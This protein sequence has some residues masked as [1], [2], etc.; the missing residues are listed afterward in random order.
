MLNKIHSA[1]ET[2][3]TTGKSL[4][5]EQPINSNSLNKQIVLNEMDS[6]DKSSDDAGE[7]SRFFSLEPNEMRNEIENSKEPAKNDYTE[8]F[9]TREPKQTRP[10]SS[11]G[12]LDTITSED[13]AQFATADSSGII[14]N[15]WN[16]SQHVAVE[17]PNHLVQEFG[18]SSKN[19]TVLPNGTNQQPESISFLDAIGGRHCIPFEI[20]KDWR[21]KDTP[22][23]LCIRLLSN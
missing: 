19:A 14:V 4:P 5:N 20:G 1:A 6:S 12:F 3:E 22:W 23:P 15:G 16:P 21:V 11:H 8:V 17:Q 13:N 18:E 9:G 10:K 2:P 7:V